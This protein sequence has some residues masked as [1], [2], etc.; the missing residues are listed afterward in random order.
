MGQHIDII[1]I[2]RAFPGPTATRCCSCLAC[3]TIA[4]LRI[5]RRLLYGLVH[6]VVYRHCAGSFPSVVASDSLSFVFARPLRCRRER[7]GC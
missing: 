3:D 6:L 2:D 1:A 7:L 4:L 5:N